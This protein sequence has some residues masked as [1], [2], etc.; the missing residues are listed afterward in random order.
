MHNAQIRG[1]L[2]PRIAPLHTYAI[3]TQVFY[4]VNAKLFNSCICAV[5]DFNKLSALIWLTVCGKAH[6]DTC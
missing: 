5:Y 3:I 1:Q 2:C 4:F 6:I